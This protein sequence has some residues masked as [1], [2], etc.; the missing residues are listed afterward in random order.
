[1]VWAI[2]IV[3]EIGRNRKNVFQIMK[4]PKDMVSTVGKPRLM[5]DH[6]TDG[7]FR[8]YHPKLDCLND[9]EDV[10]IDRVDVD[11]CPYQL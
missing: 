11:I 2:E 10:F 4:S 1:M 3:G 8:F 7:G 5:V 9:P 6:W